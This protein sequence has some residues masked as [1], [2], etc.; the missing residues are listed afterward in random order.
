MSDLW[1]PSK[2]DRRSLRNGNNKFKLHELKSQ[3]LLTEI[4]CPF[5]EKDVYQRFLRGMLNLTGS[6]HL[7]AKAKKAMEKLK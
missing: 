2:D 5:C 4:K 1:N 3:G 7:C 6:V